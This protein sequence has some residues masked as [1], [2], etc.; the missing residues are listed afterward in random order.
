MFLQCAVSKSIIFS[1][2]SQTGKIF[3]IAD[4]CKECRNDLV[5]K[6]FCCSKVTSILIMQVQQGKSC[7]GM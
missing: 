7:K 4:T 6:I 1:P 3:Y 5:L 2:N